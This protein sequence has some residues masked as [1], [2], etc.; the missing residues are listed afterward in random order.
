MRKHAEKKLISFTNFPLINRLVKDEAEIENR[1][2]SAVIETRLLESYLPSNRKA[3][4]LVETCLYCENGDIGDT[5]SA[6]FSLPSA[7]YD[8][9][10]KY[11]DLRPVLEF[12][13]EQQCLCRTIPTGKE[14]EHPH[15]CSQLD[16]VA[17]ILED[18]QKETTSSTQQLAYYHESK[19]ARDLLEIAQ[20][21]PD[22]LRYSNIYQL[23]MNN[24]DALKDHPITYRLLS[25]LAAMEKGWKNTAR[26]R[27]ELLQIIKTVA[28]E[29]D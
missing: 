16:S 23:V 9:S 18:L 17:T 3:R 26:T 5:I 25:D 13:H 6:I 14:P 8:I 24:W 29:W 27:F 28:K 19:W 12:A 4:F 10:L 15:F 21:E 20:K 2:D 7:T 1:A 11:G 22:Q